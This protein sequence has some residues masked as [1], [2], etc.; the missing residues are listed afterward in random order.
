MKKIF[1]ALAS[2]IMLGAC[3]GSCSGSGSADKSTYDVAYV[4]FSDEEKALFESEIGVNSDLYL[5]ETGI[6]DK[7]ELYEN[8]L[9]AVTKLA[10][11]YTMTDVWDHDLKMASVLLYTAQEAVPEITDEMV[12]GIV[13]VPASIIDFLGCAGMYYDFG[14]NFSM[15]YFVC[16]NEVSFT[17][18]PF[19]NR[20]AIIEWTKQRRMEPEYADFSETDLR[21]MHSCADLTNGNWALVNCGVTK[22]LSSGQKVRINFTAKLK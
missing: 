17:S 14:D 21:V 13:D 5:A 16:G 3:S 9:I 6:E 11:N 22:T 1:F 12:D 7:Y 19:T 2:I 15:T 8:N 4:N 10:D 20:N 18:M